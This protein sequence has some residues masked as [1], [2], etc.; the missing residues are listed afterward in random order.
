MARAA[1][2]VLLMISGLLVTG[3]EAAGRSGKANPLAPLKPLSTELQRAMNNGLKGKRSFGGGK[4]RVS[5]RP[6]VQQGLQKAGVVSALLVGFEFELLF[7]KGAAATYYLRTMVHLDRRGPALMSLSGRVPT[8]GKIYVTGLA[9]SAYT[10]V[11]RPFGTA[12][13]ALVRAVAQGRCL[14]LPIASAAAPQRLGVTGRLA[15]PFLRGVRRARQALPH[16]CKELASV[17][18]HRVTVRIDDIAFLARDGSRRVVGLIK[19]D[20]RLRGT[21]LHLEARGFRPA[22]P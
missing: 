18:R 1:V 14:Q 4:L 5:V 2:T 16:V 12:A 21:T 20:L 6:R 17:A 3:S 8:D 22:R 11:S 7:H 19:A 13:R 15:A 10:G 9:P